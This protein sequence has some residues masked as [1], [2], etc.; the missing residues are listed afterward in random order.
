MLGWK[1]LNRRQ[2]GT[3]KLAIS[4]LFILVFFCFGCKENPH[5][6]FKLNYN[7]HFV[8]CLQHIHG[9]FLKIFVCSPSPVVNHLNSKHTSI[10]S[11][12]SVSSSHRC[13]ICADHYCFSA[14]LSSSS[15]WMSSYQIKK[16]LT[17]SDLL[18]PPHTYTT[19]HQVPQGLHTHAHPH[20]AHI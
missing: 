18:A 19:P 6:T 14:R 1:N 5:K 12:P 7:T 11:P 8:S 4:L 2:T 20:K 3:G 13:I 15:T 10:Y 17:D 16:A 9:A